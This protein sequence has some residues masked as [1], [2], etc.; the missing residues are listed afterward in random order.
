MS[1]CLCMCTWIFNAILAFRLSSLQR[2][3]I[4]SRKSDIR[5]HFE[6]HCLRRWRVNTCGYIMPDK[7]PRWTLIPS[8]RTL[9]RSI[10]II[11]IRVWRRVKI[12]SRRS[13]PVL[14]HSPACVFINYI[15]QHKSNQARPWYGNLKPRLGICTGLQAKR[16]L[17]S[18]NLQITSFFCKFMSFLF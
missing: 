3:A 17:N 5:T 4:L 16:S 12:F 9:G 6:S 7:S 18:Q 14:R 8:Q 2:N 10:F 1:V 15:D 11:S 13:L